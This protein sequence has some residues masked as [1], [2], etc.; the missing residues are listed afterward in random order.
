MFG[1]MLGPER[2]DGLIEEVCEAFC[3]LI[4]TTLVKL[5]SI[6]TQVLD[7]N[8]D[9]EVVAPVAGPMEIADAASTRGAFPDRNVT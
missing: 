1:V 6:P 5:V 3:V 8:E 2:V 4:P 9:G 7:C